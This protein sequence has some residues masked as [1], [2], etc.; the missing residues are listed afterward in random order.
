MPSGVT[1]LT[2]TLSRRASHQASHARAL[3]V[4][5]VQVQPRLLSSTSP[6]KF[7]LAFLTLQAQPRPLTAPSPS[8][9]LFFPPSPPDERGRGAPQA[10]S[11][12]TGGRTDCSAAAPGEV[13]ATPAALPSRLGRRPAPRGTRS[14]RAHSARPLPSPTPHI[15]VCRAM[16]PYV[17]P[18]IRADELVNRVSIVVSIVSALKLKQGP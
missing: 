11:E 17:L 3:L 5:L 9:P 10:P 12:A 4:R 15:C 2:P 7:N 13:A 14:M 16:S 1:T 8:G 18:R 6:S